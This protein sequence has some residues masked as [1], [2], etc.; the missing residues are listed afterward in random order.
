MARALP[1]MALGAVAA[2][3]ASVGHV[4]G[5]GVA[6][7]VTV[8]ILMLASGLVFA[9]AAEL[10]APMWAIAALGALVQI[11]GHILMAPLGGHTGTG[12][13]AHGMPGQAATGPLNATVMHLADGGGLMIAVHAISF[14]ALVAILAL[15]APLSGLLVSLQRTLAPACIKP[16]FTIP[17]VSSAAGLVTPSVLRHIVVRRGPPVFV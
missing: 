10:R 4:A 1:G 6:A 5:G 13:H 12:A 7:P 2:L 8:A 11:A 15:A 9:A 14:A 17:A 16:A 3:L